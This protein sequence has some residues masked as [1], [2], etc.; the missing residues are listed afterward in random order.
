MK[1]HETLILLSHDHHH[2]LVV[3]LRLKKGGPAS[4]HDHW[5]SDIKAQRQALLSFAESELLPHFRLE[6]TLLF[7]VCLESNAELS[8]A[9]Q[10]LQIEHN[11]IRILLESLNA[12]EELETLRKTMSA[13]GSAI[14]MH[15]R[16]EERIFFP[17]V[18]KAI[19]AANLDLDE[20]AIAAEHAAYHLPP[21]CD[22]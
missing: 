1:R 2:G 20:K 4:P 15:I 13:L 11:A 5:P 21:S 3:A 7:P 16:K 14:E 18:E 8:Q 6:E 12:T 9:T 17:L 22:T 19:Q 10:D